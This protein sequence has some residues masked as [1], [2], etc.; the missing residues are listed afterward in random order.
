MSTLRYDGKVVVVTGAGGGLGRAYALFY[1]SRGASV[2]VNDLGSS[3]KGEQSS[4]KAADAVVQEIKAAGGKA[5]ANYDSVVDGD[6]IIATAVEAFGTVHVLVNN[7][8]IL[9]DVSFR[10]MKDA[11]WD[12]IVQVHLKGAF[13]TTKAAWPLFRKQKYGRVINTASAAG[14]YGSFGQANYSAAKLGL[15]GFTETLAKEGVKYN[16][17]AN[18]IV[19]MA[20]SRMTQTVMTEDMLALLKPEFIVPVVGL[21]THESCD[22]TGGIYETGAGFVSQVRWQRSAGA[23]FRTDDTFTPSAV[24][25]RWAEVGDFARDAQYPSGPNDF[26]SLLEDARG[27]PANAPGPA[28]DAK[29]QVVVITGAG[30]GLGRAHAFAFARAGAKVVVN[31]VGNP[32]DTVAA[33]NEQFGAGTAVADRHSAE[34]GD[35]VVKTAV[36]AFGTVHVVVNNAGILRDKS[37]A[38]LTED[39]WDAVMAVHLRGTY[40]V[41]KAAWPYFVQQKYGRVINTT[42]TSGIYGNFGQANYAAAKCAILGLTKTL[43]LEGKKY[44]IAANAIAPNAGTAMTATVLPEE[45]VQAFK[46]DYV[47]PLVVLL[48]SAKTPVTGEC[49]ETGSGWIGN[50]RWERSAGVTFAPAQLSAEAVAERWDAITDFAAGATHPA[51]T[52]ESMQP[53]LASMQAA[54]GAGAAGGAAPSE[55]AATIAK[56]VGKPSAPI[57]FAYDHRDL[58]LYNLGLGAQASELKYVYEGADDF[59][60]V[61]T[62]GVLPSFRANGEADLSELVPNFNPMMLLH[63][64]EYL[65]VRKWPLPAAAEL[66]VTRKLVDVLDKGKAAAV[67]SAADVTDASGAVVFHGES[68]VFLRGSGGFGGHSKGADRGPATAANKPPA[69]APDWTGQAKTDVDQAAVYRLSGDYN[70]LHIDP[71]FAAMAKFERPILHGLCTLGVSAKLL[72]DKFGVFRNIKVRFAGHVF[73]GE[74]LQVEAWKVGANKVVFQ[75]K[76]VER[77]T[78]AISAA[79]AEFDPSKL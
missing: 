17:Q 47:S 57:K 4:S 33:L 61:P 26:M 12:L 75:T 21:L 8:G 27:L 7:A 24:L 16:I 73:P 53:I 65:E 45:I 56:L 60:V 1:G 63:G 66:S 76:V 41:T 38:G 9:R 5:V 13:K 15:V 29:G 44:N 69:R 67:I 54:A 32:D 71:A 18:V 28:V 59:A 19:P 43:A 34:D 35:A 42:S 23:L 40:K 50:T 14:L 51:S 39:L 70:P 22:A 52:Q 49:Y 30:A 20:A 31:D 55:H 78:V 48:G 72:V 10:N 11:D 3:L 58:I 36:D 77:G 25:G 62:F 68:T 74:T 2:V 6:K 46:P 64:E 37:M 79:A